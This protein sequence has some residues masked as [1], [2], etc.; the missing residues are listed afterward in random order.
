VPRRAVT[1][2]QLRRALDVAAAQ[3]PAAEDVPDAVRVTLAIIAQ[4]NPGRSVEIRVPPYGV[5]QAFAGPRHTRGTPPNVVESDPAS[6]LALVSGRLAWR[7]ALADGSV[8]ASGTRADLS[9]VLPLTGGP[10]P[11]DGAAADDGRP[12]A[13]GGA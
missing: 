5:V 9:A 7:D 4:R 3:R 1:D 12:G 11:G 10:T 6:W 13:G 8:R 2:E